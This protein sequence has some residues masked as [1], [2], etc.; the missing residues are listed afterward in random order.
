MINYNALNIPVF[1]K[2]TAQAASILDIGCGTGEM[3][4]ALK[5][6]QPHRK[7]YGIT[8]SQSEM[9]VAE[10]Y[11]D[12]VWLVDLNE[13]I[14][15]LNT[16]FDCVILSHVLEHT[17]QPTQVLAGFTP[18]LKNSGM[19]IVALPNIMFYKQRL[20]FLRGKFTYSQEGGLMD[21]THFRFFDW[22]S[23]QQ[24]CI[25]AGFE[26]VSKEATGIFPLPIFRTLFPSIAKRIDNY[27]VR[28]YPGLFGFQFIFTLRKAVR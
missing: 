1:N 6:Q 21:V 28:V 23:A 26:I 5:K 19:S 3:G 16:E 17:Y 2:V 14:P 9:Q 27:F 8:Y 4:N 25:D 13:K 7:V 10:Q 11:L 12:K 18:Y 24:M 20:K 22:P 15:I